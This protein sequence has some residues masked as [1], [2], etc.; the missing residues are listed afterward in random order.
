M[1][2]KHILWAATI[3]VAV[4]I[5]SL[6]LITTVLSSTLQLEGPFLVTK[7][8]D[9]DTIDIENGDRIRLSGI[10]APETGECGYDEASDALTELIIGKQVYLEMDETDTGKYGRSLRY[11]YL[12][13]FSVNGHLVEEGYVKV[14][15]KYN[16]S[17]KRYEEYKEL[18]QIAQEFEKGVWSCVDPQEG[19][20]YVASKNSNIYHNPISPLKCSPSN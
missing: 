2:E 17:T 14:F 16:A 12:D 20:L 4:G 19:C 6:F 18:E 9:G 13:G 8:V 5:I 1:E 3:T 15:D 7:V 10:N 11:I